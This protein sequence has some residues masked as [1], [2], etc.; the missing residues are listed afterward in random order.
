MK[1]KIFKFFRKNRN[2]KIHPETKVRYS[3]NCDRCGNP[4][5]C[6]LLYFP[7][8][9]RYESLCYTCFMGL[10]EYFLQDK[11]VLNKEERER[12]KGI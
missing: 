11:K 8:S 1:I 9:R 4:R 2:T 5:I 6:R 12:N 3:I 10:A 7:F